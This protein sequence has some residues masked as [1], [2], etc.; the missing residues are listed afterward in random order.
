MF[1]GLNYYMS[2]L[3]T[4]LINSK[5]GNGLSDWLT[6]WLVDDSS[7]QTSQTFKKFKNTSY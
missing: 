5:D 4:Q 6:D 3:F 7:S 1:L 2:N